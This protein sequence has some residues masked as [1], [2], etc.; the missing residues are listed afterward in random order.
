MSKPIK[1][2]EGM[3]PPKDYKFN[4]LSGN[5]VFCPDPKVIN[6]VTGRCVKPDSKTLGS[7][8]KTPA[9]AP[10]PAPASVKR[11]L[12]PIQKIVSDYMT[13]I[14]K[15]KASQNKPTSLQTKKSSKSKKMSAKSV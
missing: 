6:P 3:E 2:Q 10:A 1:H 5:W 9:P 14:S 4:Q 13:E 7:S 8:S 12:K 15:I 11:Q